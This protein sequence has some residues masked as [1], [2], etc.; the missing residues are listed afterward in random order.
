MMMTSRGTV[1]SV[2][3]LLSMALAINGAVA[4]DFDVIKYDAAIEPN[5]TDKSVAGR[6][7]ITLRPLVNN[8]SQVTLND[9]ALVIDAVRAKNGAALNFE[10]RDGRLRITLPKPASTQDKIQLEI[11]YH[12][13]AKYG[14]QFYPEQRQAYTAFSTSQWMPCVDAPSDRALY[15]LSLT[16]PLGL[17]IVGNGTNVG[18]T[19]AVAGKVVSV[20]EQRTPVPTYLF[21][22]AAGDFREVVRTHRGVTF[23][24]L[25]TP[26]FTDSEIEQIFRDTA[27]MM[28]FFEARAGVKYPYSTYTQVIAAGGTQQEMAGFTVID[29]DY[30]RALLKDERENWLGAHEFAH[31]WWGNQITNIDWTHFWLNE[32]LANFMVA[33]Y[34]E[35]RF[36]RAAYD[37]EIEKLRARYE[38][39]RDAGKDKPLVF[40]DWNRPTREDRSIVYNK[41]GYVAHLLRTEMGDAAFWRGLKLYIKK[42]WGRSV[43][44]IDFQRAMEKSAKRSLR[45]F[46]DKWVYGAGAGAS[47]HK[48]SWSN[49]TELGMTLDSSSR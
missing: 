39:V 35:K 20:W 10:N 37:A 22:F 40:P 33:A 21:G 25:G 42:Y 16:V 45:A 15:R 12:G 24:Y 4:A 18:T 28:D 38:K 8:L 49:A 3:L 32:G 11:I 27:G 41:G 31:Q 14:L 43:Q 26:T 36:G 29:E 13:A 17:Q 5:W 6:V 23:R 9:G 1:F 47:A 48:S 7:T 30:G 46:F 19:P 44:T 2:L 34:K